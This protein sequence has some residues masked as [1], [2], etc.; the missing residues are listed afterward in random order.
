MAYSY[1]DCEVV[2]IIDETSDVKRF[3]IKYPDSVELKFK[4]GQ[5]IMFDL[6]ID[7]KVT[8]RSYSIASPPN[9]ENTLELVI[10][11]NPPGKGTPHL[12]EEV[13]IGSFLK[14]SMPIGKFNLVEPLEN[15]AVFIC[16]GTGIAPFRSMILD[17]IN[18]RKPFKKMTLIA[19]VRKKKDL[20]YHQEFEKLSAETPGFEYIPVLSRETAETWSGETGYVHKVYQER[21]KE[22]S[23]TTFYLCGWAAMLKEARENLQHLVFDRKQVKFESYD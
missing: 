18:T 7:S 22:P 9:S 1:I 13:K 15:E 23:A 21:Y 6:P 12:F 3:V 2:D 19:G 4:P 17:T 10:V 8:N 14:T 5:F 16:T 20:L 11:I